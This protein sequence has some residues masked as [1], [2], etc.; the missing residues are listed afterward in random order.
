MHI[1]RATRWDIPQLVALAGDAFSEARYARYPF[2]ADKARQIVHMAQDSDNIFVFVAV[3]ADDRPV[4]FLAALITEHY[5]ADMIYATNIALYVSPEARGSRAAFKLVRE[6]ERVARAK[7]AAEILLGVTSG[8]QAQRTV[9]FYNRLG[10][11]T[12][13]A[14]TV[15]YIGE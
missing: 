8:V 6:F 9:E 1:R 4:G 10:F 15:K 7:G 11:Q 3:D 12:V 2:S 14:L 13:G 5:F